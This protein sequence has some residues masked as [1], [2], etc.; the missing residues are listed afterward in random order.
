MS[1]SAGTAVFVLTIGDKSEVWSSPLGSPMKGAQGGYIA[2]GPLAVS[3]SSVYGMSQPM[4]TQQM[5]MPAQQVHTSAPEY[6]LLHND[7]KALYIH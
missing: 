5:H 7:H 2:Q 6:Q 4:P 3:A 1:A